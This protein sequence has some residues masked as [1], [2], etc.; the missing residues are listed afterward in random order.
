M[1]GM[2]AQT[3]W[4]S[5]PPPSPFNMGELWPAGEESME[6]STNT[7]LERGTDS[8]PSQIIDS[9][10]KVEEE[11]SRA[12]LFSS[13]D[14]GKKYFNFACNCNALE[15][16]H[17][18]E[19]NPVV[20]V[21]FL[22]KSI[23]CIGEKSGNV[24]FLDLEDRKLS[25]KAYKVHNDPI[26]KLVP[27]RERD[28]FTASEFR[29]DAL[30]C[31]NGTISTLFTLDKGGSITCMTLAKDILFVGCSIEA[32][33]FYDLTEGQPFDFF[34]FNRESKASI[35]SLSA[36]E[37]VLVSS[38]VSASPTLKL[39]DVR[40]RKT[41]SEIPSE[42]LGQIV[43]TGFDEKILAASYKSGWVVAWD[44]R[45]LTTPLFSKDHARGAN[46]SNIKIIGST[47]TYSGRD[48]FY[49]YDL[50]EAEA[51]MAPVIWMPC[52][53]CAHD[54][55][56]IAIRDDRMAYVDNERIYISDE[57]SSLS[58]QEH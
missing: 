5:S 57:F 14:V 42:G 8:T 34:N 38:A 19:G 30:D 53:C 15:N 4:Y 18:F 44:R 55:T 29:V 9:A 39:W 24:K 47:L 7:A 43:E 16:L 37:G 3:D 33:L 22:S 41:L 21:A 13:S 1:M 56:S 36:Y 23:L 48:A 32:I 52:Q 2:S 6:E 51:A 27:Y 12:S 35:T 11:Y 17:C 25:S 20:K 40:T 28:L 49:I 50:T 45:N 10:R 26:I 31:N 46:I 54:I 58:K